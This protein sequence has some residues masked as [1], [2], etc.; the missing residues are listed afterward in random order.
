MSETVAKLNGSVN[1]S[2]S[3]CGRVCPCQDTRDSDRVEG[4]PDPESRG[5][6]PCIEVHTH[7]AMRRGDH[8]QDS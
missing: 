2:L 3:F 4:S 5:I 6:G 1:D 8:G 7:A